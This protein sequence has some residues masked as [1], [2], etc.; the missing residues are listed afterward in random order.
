MYWTV[1]IDMSEMMSYICIY[2][3]NVFVLAILVTE[4]IVLAIFINWID[5]D[6]YN[7]N[8]VISYYYLDV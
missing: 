6:Y 7:I 2:I 4:Y 1:E 3:T 8:V 5:K